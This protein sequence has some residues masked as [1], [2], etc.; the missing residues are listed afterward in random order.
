MNRGIAKKQFFKGFLGRSGSSKNDAN[1]NISKSINARN[2]IK[3]K[4]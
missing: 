2:S 3:A 1:A 4:N